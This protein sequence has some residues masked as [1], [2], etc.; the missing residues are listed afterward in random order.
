MT[1]EISNQNGYIRLLD[2]IVQEFER[3]NIIQ[4]KKISNDLTEYCALNN[5]FSGLYLAVV[6]YV[7]HKTLTQTH[8]VESK[9]WKRD[10]ETILAFFDRLKK[11]NKDSLQK[12]LKEFTNLFAKTNSELFRYFKAI[13]QKGRIK[14]GARL[15]SMSFSTKRIQELLYVNLYDLQ[16]YISSSQMQNQKTNENLI[17]NKVDLLAKETKHL[18]FDSSALISIGN[19]GII[20]IFEEFK[21]RNPNI[22]L[23][24]TES[25]HNETIDIQDKVIRYGWIGVQYESLI[26]QGIFTLIKDAELSKDKTIGSLCNNV[27]S[28]K[29][30]KLELLQ[31]GELDCVIF[32]KNNN[33][34][35]VIDEI[36]TRWLI[37]NPF[38]IHDLMESRYKEKVSFDRQKL[39]LISTTLKNIPVVRSV[40][41]VSFAIKQKY[42]S[43]LE[44]L[45]YK[46]SLLYSIKHS[47]CATT[48]EEIDSYINN[49]NIENKLRG[50]KDVKTKY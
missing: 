29:H 34:V 17:K 35:L 8:L 27:F 13:E 25:V 48:Y 37:E 28:T 19:T 15:Y 7:L 18:V 14:I 26:Q 12:N 4:L 9:S 32:A 20:N 3:Q 31:K 39:N 23:Y 10:K 47:G 45:N 38:K 24:L 21:K 46:K 30:G 22:Y 43:K 33:A 42:F 36:V 5:D 44:G 41:F 40:D 49:A 16:N 11:Q 50:N 2:E 6:V 1:I